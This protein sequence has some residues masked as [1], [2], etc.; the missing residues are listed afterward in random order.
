MKKERY[1]VEIEMPDGDSASS[2]W[3]RDTLQGEDEGR[4]KVST[5]VMQNPG[6]GE[7]DE[8]DEKRLSWVINYFNPS[9]ELY[10]NLIYWLKSLKD[11]IQSQSQWNPNDKDKLRAKQAIMY[12][13][14]KLTFESEKDDYNFR[15]GQIKWLKSLIDRVQPQPKQEWSEKDMGYIDDLI[16][17]FSQNEKLENTKE[18]IIAWLK[19]LKPQP[20]QE[21]SDEDEKMVRALMSICDEWATR[22]SYLPK[23]DNDIEKI[24]SW[25]KSY[26]LKNN[27]TEEELYGARKDA[28]NNALDKIE[29]HSGDPTFDDGWWAAIDYIQKKFLKPQNRWEPSDDQIKAIRLARSFVTD[30][31]ADNPT[32]SEILMELEKQ[33]QKIKEN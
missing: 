22:H 3:V 10:S 23:E 13:S 1:I 2:T 31:F 25:L 28:F 4:W 6:W 8:E 12:L 11:R 29:Y 14:K 9:G 20:K 26:K 15:E 33:L 5:S 27:I 19:S 16:A 32:L 7:W 17:H 30:D 21:C 18:D 24:K